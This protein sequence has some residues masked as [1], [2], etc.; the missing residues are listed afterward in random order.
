[1]HVGQM[2]AKGLFRNPKE[3]EKAK[4]KRSM[5]EPFYDEY[6]ID[7][8]EEFH[9]RSRNN[10]EEGDKDLKHLNWVFLLI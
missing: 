10:Q 7:D 1:M 6:E 8:E 2:N 9:N 4:G 3:A 5:R